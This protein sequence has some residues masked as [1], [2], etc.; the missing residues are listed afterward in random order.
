MREMDEKSNGTSNFDKLL[1]GFFSSQV[2][3]RMEMRTPPH[4]IRRNML[5]YSTLRVNTGES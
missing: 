5:R 3:H 2:M 1:L 4:F